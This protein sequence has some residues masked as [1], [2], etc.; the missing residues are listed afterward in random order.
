MN[1]KETELSLGLPGGAQ[2]V[3]TPTK[4]GL[5]NKRGFSETVDLKFSL[6][7]N[8]Q[9][10]VNLI[11]SGTVPKDKILLKDPAKPPTK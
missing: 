6:H 3:E 10:P 11:V 5:G 4:S 9:G 7:S 2:A 1:H 8:K